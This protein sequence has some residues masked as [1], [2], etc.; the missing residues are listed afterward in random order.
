MFLWVLSMWKQGRQTEVW[1]KERE[2][3]VREEVPR[4]SSQRVVTSSEVGV[5]EDNSTKK[6]HFGVQGSGRTRGEERSERKGGGK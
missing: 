5:E 6:V 2:G 4:G 3:V 1:L